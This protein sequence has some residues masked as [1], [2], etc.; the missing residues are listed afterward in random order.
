MITECYD[1]TT[2]PIINLQDF[3]GEAKHIADLCLITFSKKLHAHL[4]NTCRCEE[5]GVI[6][7]CNGNTS[8]YKMNYKGREI[9]FYLS[10]I[11]SAIASGMCCEANH[12][13][14]A[15]KFIMFGS[16]GSLNIE[17]TKG[18]F[19][20]PTESYRGE[21]CSYYYAAPADYITVKNSARLAAI[22]EKSGIPY[23]SGKV[24]T[25]ETM[26]RETAGL[27]AKRKAEG[28]IAVDMEL[29]GVQA[30]CDFYNFELF[31]F[32]EAGDVLTESH[33]EIA[34]L[35]SANHD[36]GKLY[37]ALEIALQL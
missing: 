15:T 32:L 21:G 6:T 26:L 11:G 16:C 19:I 20:I 23:V 17:K 35:H 18:K 13:I 8:I 5:I 1:V 34:E 3:Y 36:L 24:W 10:A 25:T 7:A 33:Y 29:S 22:F 30:V 31:N 9:A 27:V 14:G 28:C 4:L 37:L 2:E 12:I